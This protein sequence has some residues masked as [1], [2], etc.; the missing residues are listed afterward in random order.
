MDNNENNLDEQANQNLT[1]IPPQM[2]N[3]N[4]PDNTI[5]NNDGAQSVDSFGQAPPVEPVIGAEQNIQANQNS[6][7]PNF[8][9]APVK[10][11]LKTNI[12]RLVLL[13]GMAL[14]ITIIFTTYNFISDNKANKDSVGV[15]QFKE[16]SNTSIT[17][18]SLLDGEEIELLER[19]GVEAFL[20][21]TRIKS[22]DG[23]LI[24]DKK[25]SGTIVLDGLSSLN[26]VRVTKDFVG[27]LLF[28]N[29]ASAEG[30]ILEDG[31][32]QSIS[33][34][35]LISAKGLV[36]PSGVTDGIFIMDNLKSATG[37]IIP[38]DFSG[39]LSLNG[40]VDAKDLVIPIGFSGRID[41][42]GVNNADDLI[43]PDD[44]SG[45]IC[46]KEGG[47]VDI[48]KINI[49]ESATGNIKYWAGPID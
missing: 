36:I 6:N 15:D 20:R 16:V 19:D 39:E 33:L 37:L 10:T 42:L 43:I 46:F 5:A 14:V 38:N 28:P 9:G 18:Y 35:G 34:N 31:F 11:S 12:L 41:L 26:K 4:N 22:F 17:L 21:L 24:I 40:L 47:S 23:E 30:L 29:A 49:P 27:A 8:S 13:L 1:S 32:N 45:L 48:N 7:T 25:I 44:F 2:L 3:P